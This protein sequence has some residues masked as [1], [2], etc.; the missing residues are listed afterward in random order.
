MMFFALQ[1][2]PR[3]IGASIWTKHS[4]WRWRRRATA[5]GK[6]QV[7]DFFVFFIRQA[8]GAR[9]RRWMALVNA[10][11]FNLLPFLLLSAARSPSKCAFSL[12][13]CKAFYRRFVFGYQTSCLSK[14]PFQVKLSKSFSVRNSQQL[15]YVCLFFYS[16]DS[17]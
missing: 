1:H 13:G 9:D 16:R 12:V 10:E 6:R 7:Q 11:N 8:V 2:T 14:S 15:Q 17:L 5:N 4:R 3:L